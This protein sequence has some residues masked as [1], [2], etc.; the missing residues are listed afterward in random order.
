M[1]ESFDTYRVSILN[2]IKRL[3]ENLI[4]LQE[5]TMSLTL[6]VENL[7]A[8]DKIRSALWGSTGGL[9]SATLIVLL[10]RMLWGDLLVTK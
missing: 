5:A 3:G 1:T 9:I 2:D 10:V 7:K 8:T 4:K 6:A